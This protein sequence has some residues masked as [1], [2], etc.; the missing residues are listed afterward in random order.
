MEI[1]L[2]LRGVKEGEDKKDV[3]WAARERK[4]NLTFRWPCKVIN[5]YNKTNYM[6]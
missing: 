3:L 5:S 1:V 2:K 6:H 4:K